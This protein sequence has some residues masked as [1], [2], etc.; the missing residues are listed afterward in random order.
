MTGS[1]QLTINR[2]MD[3]KLRLYLKTVVWDFLQNNLTRV[4]FNQ[5]QK[6]LHSLDTNYHVILI[7]ECDGTSSTDWILRDLL[8]IMLQYIEVFMEYKQYD[9]HY[10]LTNDIT[11]PL[12]DLISLYF[13]EF[14]EQHTT[15][16][17]CDG[18]A[19]L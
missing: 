1:G 4:D 10:I 6:N 12:G 17:L 13:D 8:K 9:V 7:T 15:D 3:V 11:S 19:S 5:M 18:I 16:E 2:D 14:Y